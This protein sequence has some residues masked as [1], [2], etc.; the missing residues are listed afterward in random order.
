MHMHKIDLNPDTSIHKDGRTQ[1]SIDIDEIFDRSK[2]I[3]SLKTYVVMEF[4]LSI[5]FD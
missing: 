5:E 1:A 4:Y 2:Q 3:F